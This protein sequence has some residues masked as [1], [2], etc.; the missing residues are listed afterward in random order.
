ME[1]KRTG[2]SG[3]EMSVWEAYNGGGNTTGQKKK[4]GNFLTFF[5]LPHTWE[6]FNE[7]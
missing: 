3:L 4:K 2:L 7:T 1:Y 5:Q 6:E